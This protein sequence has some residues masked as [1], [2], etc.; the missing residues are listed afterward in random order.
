MG[1]TP[2]AARTTVAR[3]AGWRRLLATLT[4]S[5]V[6][7][8]TAALIHATPT[9]ADPK[10]P[11]P[12]PD[13]PA[14]DPSEVAPGKRA[15]L[16]GPRWRTSKDR[17]WVTSGDAD[18]LHVLVADAREGYRWR[19]AATLSE[20]GF[21]TDRWIGNACV[22]GSGRRL[23]VAYAPRTFTNEAA[24]FDRGRSRRWST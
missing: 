16:L 13:S 5:V 3:G 19:T 9:Q 24:L 10:A 11:P 14:A 2:L 21:D 4:A 17:A 6:L 22:T 23:V 15:A 12:A 8:S 1:R 18:G 20:P 7:L